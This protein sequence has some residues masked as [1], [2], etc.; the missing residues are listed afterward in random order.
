MSRRI[1]RE[2]AFQ[3]LFQIDVGRNTPEAA[4]KYALD[5]NDL[6]EKS[7]AFLEDVVLGTCRH[8]KEID[9]LLGQFAEG[10]TLDRMGAT[11]RNILRMAIYE[12]VYREDVPIS[13]TVN[14]AV[15]LAKTYGDDESGKF[16]NG[17]LGNIIRQFTLPAKAESNGEESPLPVESVQEETEHE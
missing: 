12:L 6:P 3:T 5:N 9:E 15:E 1:A 10:W 4:L 8:V 17:I 13:V 7:V 16:V 2:L 11:D 14:E